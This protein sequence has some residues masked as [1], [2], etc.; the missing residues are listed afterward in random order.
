MSICKKLG[1]IGFLVLLNIVSVF[2]QNSKAFSWDLRF[3]RA[4]TM[5]PAPTNRLVEA[6]DGDVFLLS[7]TPQ[8]DVYCYTIYVTTERKYV[9]LY[10]ATLPAGVE[11]SFGR[12]Q[13]TSPSGRETIYIFM[14]ASRQITL[15]SL[16]REYNRS[17]SSQNTAELNNEI[18]ALRKKITDLGEPPVAGPTAGATT[19][20]GDSSVMAFTTYYGREA[21]V[22]TI[23]I[24]H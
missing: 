3:L 12:L 6:K 4:D 7:I 1:I 18:S 9:V 14:T 5:F 23:T 22:R 15:E 8:T 13:I 2:S 19:R 20:E 16:I 17:P 21:Y 10:D 11:K 24:R